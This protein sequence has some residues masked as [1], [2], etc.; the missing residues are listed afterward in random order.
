MLIYVVALVSGTLLP[1]LIQKLFIHFKKFDVVNYRSSHN[2]SATRTGGIGIFLTLFVITLYQYKLKDEIFDFSLLIP[3]SIMFIVGVYDDL[4]NA[5]FKLKFLL[6]VIVA[7]LIIDQGYVIDN[8]YG[9][10][11][12]YEVSWVLAQASTVFVFLVLVNAINFIDGIDG[13]AI[14]EVIKSIIIIEL[15]S[16]SATP[17][18][19]LGIIVISSILPLYYFNFRK[20]YKVF[21]GD[22]GSLFLGTLVA[23]YV[24]NLLGPNFNFNEKYLFNKTLF[25]ICL[26]IYPL[27]DLIRVFFIRIIKKKSPFSPD[28]NHLHHLLLK[29]FNNTFLVILIIQIIHIIIF[30]SIYFL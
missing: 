2:T 11:G 1:I 27:F 8:Y 14:T 26:F 30:A 24:F 19:A 4:Y 28:K 21:L 20:K 17:L 16:Y 3:L 15:I 18:S 22:G 9:L 29:K 25:S 12:L 5:N 7:K 23:I 6:Q 10:F 13:L